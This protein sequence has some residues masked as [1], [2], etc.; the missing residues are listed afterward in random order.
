MRSIPPAGRRPSNS[1]GRVWIALT[2]GFVVALASALAPAREAMRVTPTEAMSRGAH[3]HHARLRWRRGLLWSALSGA[4]ALAASQAQPVARAI[5]WGDTWPRCSP[6][7]RQRWAAPAE[8]IAVNRRPPDRVLHSH[9]VGLLAGRSLT[10]SL[11]RTS[12]VVVALATAIAMMASVGI[13]VG[14][15]RETVALWL[16]TQLRA[17]L[18]CV[19]RALRRPA[20]YPAASPP[21]SPPF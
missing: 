8:V 19:P 4:L 10:A 13:M 11:S 12:V 5:R 2:T 3:E 16:D 17:D 14:S 6:S 9:V 18:T 20:D 15:F 1:R 7:E 21:R